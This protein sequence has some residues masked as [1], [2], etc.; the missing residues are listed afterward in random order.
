MNIGFDL[1]ISRVNQAG[2]GVY[3]GKLAEALARRETAGPDAFTFFSVGQQREMSAPKTARSRLA[4]LY[5]DI[6][7]LHV[8]LPF[9]ARRSSVDVLHAPAGIAPLHAPCPVVVSILDTVAFRMSSSL[10]A[11]QRFY[12]RMM[13]PRSERRAAAIVTISEHSKREIVAQFHVPADKVK[14]AYLA[15]GDEFRVLPPAATE[16]V[17]Q[18]YHLGRFLLSVGTVEP[19]KNLV[20]LMEA[21]ATLRDSGSCC[22]LVH[23]GP[24][25]WMSD[26]LQ[27]AI[28]GL[29]LQDAVR[30][31]G[32]VPIEDLVA[33]YNAADAFI[34][35][36]LYE[37]FGLPVVEAMA[38]GCPVVTSNTTSLPEVG[39]QAAILVD[40]CR[41]DAIAHAVQRVLT[42]PDLARRMREY[43]LAQAA[44]F[45]W[46]RCAAETLNAY[47]EAALR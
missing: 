4:T 8:L 33:L 24:A 30:F 21:L 12:F 40:P 35:P 29:G 32:R 47:R 2:T 19:R 28:D 42:E 20:R 18:R 6:V 10:P 14:V 34:Y 27:P 23:A 44:R 39:G 13:V 9:Q 16:A 22:Q 45:S 31:L 7:W 11:W 36:S 25:G 1:S 46:D 43:G 3:A 17:R 15:A 37:G 38:C 26:D 41:P 5:R